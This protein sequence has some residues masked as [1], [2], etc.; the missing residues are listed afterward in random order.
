MDRRAAETRRVIEAAGTSC[1]TLVE[2]EVI[3][4]IRNDIRSYSAA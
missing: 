4:W 3:I 2:S 1:Y